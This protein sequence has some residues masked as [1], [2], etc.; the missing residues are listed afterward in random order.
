MPADYL[1]SDTILANARTLGPA[2]ESAADAIARDRRLPGD[3]IESMRRAGIFRIAFP[4][5]W[6]GPEMD[7]LQQ[8]E[9]MEILGYRDAS[10]AW[11]AMICSDSGHYAA[12]VEES[13]ARELYP[14]LDLLTA[15]W[16]APVGQAHRVEGGFKV[17]GR[18]QFGSGCLHA[19]RLIGGCLVLENGAPVMGDAN[20]PEFRVVWLPT[21]A[22]EIH[23]T[24]YTTGLAGSGSNDYSVKECFV[25]EARSFHP[26]RVGARPEPLYRYH[27]FF[28]A[29]LPAVALG[30]ARRMIDDLRALALHK[31]VMPAMQLM[32][33]EYRV[34]VALADATARL[35]AARAYQNE[36]IGAVWDTLLRGDTPS[37]EQRAGIGLMSVHAIQSALQVA[38]IVCEAAGST[39]L[40]AASPFDRR[41]RDLMTIACHIVGQR[42]AF[43]TA[44]QLLFG[45]DVPTFV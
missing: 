39:A 28:F 45:D 30:C 21:D 15:G 37:L 40:Y 36:R 20:L 10:A 26:F 3:L 17:S 18:W 14:D 11:V 7:I 6:G 13:V 19:D 1:D 9:L 27:G 38:D 33:D 44:G 2:I 41:R 29:N 43:Q 35:G 12:R 25:P 34:Q 31:M 8:C 5:A 24:W 23:D 22:V 16:L 42:R 32:K 4:R